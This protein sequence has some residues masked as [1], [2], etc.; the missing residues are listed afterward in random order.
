MGLL[1]LLQQG[2]T[3]LSAGSFPGDTPINDPQ[4]GFVQSTSPTNTYSSETIGQPDNG[5]VLANTLSNTVL[6]NTN[7]DS[8]TTTPFP[9]SSTN[10]PEFVTGKFGYAPHSFTF[11]YSAYNNGIYTY[12]STNYYNNIIDDDPNG[13]NPQIQTL[14]QTSLDNTNPNSTSATVNPLSVDTIYPYFARGKWKANALPFSQIWGANFIYNDNYVSNQLD[15]L[16]QTSLD[17]TLLARAE[18]TDPIPNVDSAPNEYIT[19]GNLPPQVGMGMFGFGPGQYNSNYNWLGGY[20][21]QNNYNNIIVT[22]DNPLV[23]YTPQS[24]LSINNNGTAV[25]SLSNNSQF[26]QTYL[27]D[28]GFPDNVTGNWGNNPNVFQQYYSPSNTYL[29]DIQQY[30]G[31]HPENELSRTSLDNTN[32][33]NWSNMVPDSTAYPNHYPALVKGEFN[34]APS[35]YVSPYNSSSTY[36]DSVPIQ[37]DNSPQIPTLSNSA[38]DNTGSSAA[39][40]TIPDY[41]SYPNYYPTLVSGEFNGAPS[42]YVTPYNSDNPYLNSVPIQTSTSPQSVSLENTGLDLDNPEHAST[43]TTPDSLTYPN[44][45]PAIETVNLAGFGGP[46]Q[47]VTNWNPTR[48]YLDNFN[49]NLNNSVQLTYTGSNLDNSSNGASTIS[50]VTPPVSEYIPNTYPSIPYVHLGKFNGSPFQYTTP[51]SPSNSYMQTYDSVVNQNTNTQV[52]TLDKT[53]LDVDNSDALPS[54]LLLAPTNPDTITSYPAIAGVNLGATGSAANQ[55]NQTYKPSNTYWG[56]YQNN[57]SLFDA[58]IA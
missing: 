8:T 42:Q 44:H 37:T 58:L 43:T 12:L 13:T 2:K 50:H 29:G 16:S 53:G 26:N 57:R 46:E 32:S 48:T 17:N 23:I 28:I 34:G 4:S 47:Y 51:Y 33:E 54:S 38:L 15:T 19:M 25:F 22:S 11:P 20:Y 27:G 36:L 39:T 30:G 55:F 41:I 49:F 7:P 10:Y 24:G 1:D 5:S 14:S 3:T 45:Y 52:N 18:T 21:S 6:D 9:Q 56:V 31:V 40:T 35:Q